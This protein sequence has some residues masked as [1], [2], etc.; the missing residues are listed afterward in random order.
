MMWFD[1]RI[2]GERRFEH[3]TRGLA[4]DVLIGALGECFRGV[5]RPP[6]ADIALLGREHHCAETRRLHAPVVLTAEH[7]QGIARGETGERRETPIDQ[8]A[9]RLG[10]HAGARNLRER[11]R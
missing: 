7:V 9:N 11:P 3:H 5:R 2:V 10:A 1:A 8:S 6:P 4:H